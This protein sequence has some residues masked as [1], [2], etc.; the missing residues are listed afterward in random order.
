MIVL[1]SNVL[2]F[3]KNMDISQDVSVP[4]SNAKQANINPSLVSHTWMDAKKCLVSKFHTTSSKL[5]CVT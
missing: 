4:S 5:A 1:G 2:K 3:I